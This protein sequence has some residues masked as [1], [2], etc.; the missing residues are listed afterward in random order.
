MALSVDQ[1]HRL[2][3]A[4]PKVDEVDLMTLLQAIYEKHYTGSFTVHCKDGRPQVVEF[5][6][7]KVRLAQI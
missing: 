5:D 4:P 7:P 6:P 2:L 3:T 1:L